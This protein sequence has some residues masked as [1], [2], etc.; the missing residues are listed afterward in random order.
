VTVEDIVTE[1]AKKKFRPVY[2]LEGEESYFID[3]V[4]DYAEN[5]ILSE[6][7]KAFNLSIFYGKDSDATTITHSCMKYPMFGERQLIL[8]K[9]AQMLRDLSKL[10]S[11]ITKP[12]NTTILIV[13]HKEKKLDG[14]SQLSKYVTKNTGYLY[15]KK[16]SDSELPRWVQQMAQKLGVD[17]QQKAQLL[18]MDHTGNDLSRLKNEIEK[19]IINL[20]G[21]TTITEDDVEAYT[22]I[23]KEFN[24]FELQ[25]A[26]TQKNLAK[27]I[28]IIQYFEANPKAGPIQLILPVLYTYF[29]KLYGMTGKSVVTEG[30][31]KSA[32]PFPFNAAKDALLC[33][34]NYGYEG[35]QQCLLMLYHY[36]LR[37]LGVEDAGTDNASLLKEMVTKILHK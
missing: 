14:R 2:W 22:G 15:S 13:A 34:N 33:Y 17:L 37:S 24:V 20:N 10:E 30:D 11:Y 26:I 6:T 5:H 27:A 1:M 23:S 35:I 19:I 25:Q 29:S 3:Q 16:L 8:V 18:L 7:E 31:L 36:N 21:R 9:E 12:L 28:R 4:T 32:F